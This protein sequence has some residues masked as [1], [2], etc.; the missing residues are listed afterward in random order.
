MAEYIP[1][2]LPLRFK[3]L[4]Y[5]ERQL[6]MMAR[7]TEETAHWFR[8]SKTPHL[9]C[10]QCGGQGN[11]TKAKDGT[12]RPFDQNDFKHGSDRYI[13]SCPKCRGLGK[14]VCTLPELRKAYRK[15]RKLVCK[16][17]AFDHASFDRMV[18]KRLGK[19]PVPT[20]WYEAARHLARTFGIES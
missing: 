6:E 17:R 2:Y 15:L 4:D 1:Q 12:R 9:P 20:A 19:D 14:V 16:E 5:I 3:H 7:T 13:G 10:K 18:K 11:Y 8:P